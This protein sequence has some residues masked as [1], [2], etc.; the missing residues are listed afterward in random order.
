MLNSGVYSIMIHQGSFVI[1]TLAKLQKVINFSQRGRPF[2]FH[3]VV[4]STKFIVCCTEHILIFLI[5]CMRSW[6]TIA[7][8]Y[9]LTNYTK[10]AQKA[11]TLDCEKSWKARTQSGENRLLIIDHQLHSI[12][13]ISF[14]IIHISIK[15]RYLRIIITIFFSPSSIDHFHHRHPVAFNSFEHLAVDILRQIFVQLIRESTC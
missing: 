6:D 12:V 13:I 8:Q 1:L 5:Q 2:L 7:L 4:E 3:N 14:I 11:T 15:S 10:L 9:K